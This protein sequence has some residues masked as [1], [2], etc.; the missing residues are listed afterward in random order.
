MISTPYSAWFKAGGERGP[1]VALFLALARWAAKHP[2]EDSYLFVASSGHELGGAGIKSFMDKYAPPPDQVT[3]WLHLGA[4]IS[5]YD[6]EK[7][8]KE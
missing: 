3:C 7:T 2:T 6:W 5:A 4:S 1:G 8:P